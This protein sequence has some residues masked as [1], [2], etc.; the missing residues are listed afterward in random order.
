MTRTRSPA[1]DPTGVANRLEGGEPGDRQ[2]GGLLE[3]EPG[4]LAGHSAFRHHSQ[5]GEGPVGGADHLVPD[6][7]RGDLRPDLGDDAGHVAARNGVL[8]AAEP[9]GEADGVGV[10]GHQVPGAAVHPGCADAHDHV[11]RTG[12]RVRHLGQ[13]QLLAAAVAVLVDGSHDSSFMYDVCY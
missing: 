1:P 4:R 9:E 12:G 10:P 8:G 6:G 3:G 7:H 11:V 5:L 2:R 13:G